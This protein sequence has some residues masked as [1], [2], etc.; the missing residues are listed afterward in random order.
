MTFLQQRYIYLKFSC[1]FLL[2][3]FY[4]LFKKSF[5][6]QYNENHFLYA[7]AKHIKNPLLCFKVI[8][9]YDFL[10]ECNS[11]SVHVHTAFHKQQNTKKKNQDSSLS[12]KSKVFC[13]ALFTSGL[14]ILSNINY[15]NKNG[16]IMGL[17][18]KC[19]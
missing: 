12:K 16:Y 4:F 8:L 19:P 14:N 6:F 15:F 10:Y 7:S 13:I 1:Y 18:T 9:K 3:Y 5:Y 11:Y 17:F 2:F